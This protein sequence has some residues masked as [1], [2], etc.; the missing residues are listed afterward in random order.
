MSFADME[1]NMA[2]I[3]MIIRAMF[4]GYVVLFITAFFIQWMVN[5]KS[6]RPTDPEMVALFFIPTSL[7]F[8]TVYLLA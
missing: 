5:P 2:Q 8:F 7:A 6:K 3:P 4:C 1:T